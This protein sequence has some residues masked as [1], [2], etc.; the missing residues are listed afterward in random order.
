M[1]P[2][3]IA[4][5]QAAFFPGLERT[6]TILGDLSEE[7]LK[8][9]RKEDVEETLKN[10]E[11]LMKAH[12]GAAAYEKSESFFL[13][14]ALKCYRCA[15]LE[16]RLHGLAYIEEAIQMVSRKKNSMGW[17]HYESTSSAAATA[18]SYSVRFLSFLFLFFFFF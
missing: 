16:K 7:E 3:L 9:V 14:F 6:F 18:R 2:F 13:S 17:D 15:N 4:D 11:Q 1:R 12:L 10:L 5:L 8:L